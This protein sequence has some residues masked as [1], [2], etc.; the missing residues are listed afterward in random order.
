MN[1]V[2]MLMLDTSSGGSTG[3]RDAKSFEGKV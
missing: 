3:W 2:M 1:E